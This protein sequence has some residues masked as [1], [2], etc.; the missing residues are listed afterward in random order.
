[1][2]EGSSRVSRVSAVL[3]DLPRSGDRSHIL[4]SVK[5]SESMKVEQGIV[6][7]TCEKR[8]D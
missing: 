8:V 3:E 7:G 4:M 5:Y 6:R 1:V 2:S